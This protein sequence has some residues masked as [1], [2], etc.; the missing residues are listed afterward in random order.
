[1]LRL[2]VLQENSISFRVSLSFRKTCELNPSIPCFVHDE[3]RTNRVRGIQKT[4]TRRI[5][6]RTRGHA[7]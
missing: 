5:G 7:D 4:E 2:Y 1:M 6:F 3:A